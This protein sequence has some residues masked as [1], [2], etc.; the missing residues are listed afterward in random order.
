MPKNAKYQ[1]LAKSVGTGKVISYKYTTDGGDTWNDNNEGKLGSVKV[2][3]DC[4][5]E[6]QFSPAIG[7]LKPRISSIL[8]YLNPTGNVDGLIH[9]AFANSIDGT[10]D[11]Y[12]EALNN[13]AEAGTDVHKAIE[14]YFNQPTPFPPDVPEGFYNFVKKYNPE[15]IKMEQRIVDA[16]LGI[17][18]QYDCLAWVD[19]KGRRVLACID[20]KTSKRVSTKHKLQCSFYTKNIHKRGVVRDSDIVGMVV[21]FGVDNKQGYSCSIIEEADWKNNYQVICH[22][23][24][25]LDLLN[26]KYRDSEVI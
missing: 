13:T 11:G 18:G 1:E 3:I 25:M 24:A 12:K 21:A 8:S 15:V 23:K 22:L 5:D 19:I 16:Q 17:T 26:I 20:W 14:N 4:E 10:F 7:Q 6:D 2:G 9:W